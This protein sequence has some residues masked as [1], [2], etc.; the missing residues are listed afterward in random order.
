LRVELSV[1]WGL[2]VEEILR[3]AKAHDVDLIAMGAHGRRGVGDVLLYRRGR[4]RPR[5]ARPCA[6]RACGTNELAHEHHVELPDMKERPRWSFSS[7]TTS[8]AHRCTS[9]LGT[10]TAV[11]PDLV[12]RSHQP[13]QASGRR[14]APRARRPPTSSKQAACCHLTDFNWLS[15]TCWFNRQLGAAV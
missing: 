10:V 12:T 4:R 13:D 8:P 11:W 9:I 5:R 7:S 3:Y 14:I 2:P 6:D 15:D 1:E